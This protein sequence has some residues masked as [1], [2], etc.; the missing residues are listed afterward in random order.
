MYPEEAYIGW[1]WLWA[2]GSNR[3][4]IVET[5]EQEIDDV[6]REIEEDTGGLG[7]L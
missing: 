7:D 1:A 5:P 4:L 2:P 3:A 6:Y